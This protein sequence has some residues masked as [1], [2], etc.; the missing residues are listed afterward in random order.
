MI[1]LDH[2]M[3]VQGAVTRSRLLLTH[4]LSNSRRWKNFLMKLA[5]KGKRLLYEKKEKTENQ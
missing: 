2:A 3:I 1:G 5:A 4:M